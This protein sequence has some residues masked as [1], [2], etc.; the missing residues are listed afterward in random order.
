MRETEFDAFLAMLDDVHALLPRGAAQPLSASARAMFFRALLPY[1]LA[2]VRAAFDAH[3]RDPQRGRFAPVP[4]DLIAQIGG[5]AGDDGR[6]GADEAWSI[7]AQG[8]DETATVVWTDEIARAW[9]VARPVMALGDE[10]GARMAFREAYTRGLRM[11]RESGEPVR[12]VASLGHDP[13]GRDRALQEAA[14][15]GRIAASPSG[16]ALPAPR[17]D[18]LALPAAAPGAHGPTAEV[19]AML[20][21]LRERMANPPQGPDRAEVER[22]ELAAKKAAA[23]QAAA[24]HIGAAA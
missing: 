22:A 5:S 3:V 21:A 4:A 6:L 14:R 15:L 24:K 19:R 23:A 20:L 12:W 8:V 1:E 7:A 9:G 11:A 13:E 2:A 17:A 16:H 18:L 10:V